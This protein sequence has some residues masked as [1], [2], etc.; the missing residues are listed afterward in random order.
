MCISVSPL[1]V[2]Y[3]HTCQERAL[4]PLELELWV[5]VESH[6]VAGNRTWVLW[7]NTQCS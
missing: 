6:V 1:S 4:D 7:K 3:I 2:Y 5:L